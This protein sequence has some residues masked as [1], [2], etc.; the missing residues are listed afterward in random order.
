MSSSLVGLTAILNLRVS[1]SFVAVIL[2]GFCHVLVRSIW[3]AGAWLVWSLVSHIGPPA[4]FCY[5]LTLVLASFVSRAFCGHL[6]S[7]EFFSLSQ[8]YS[9]GSLLL[10]WALPVPLR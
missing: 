1:C 4:V 3:C 7:G 5:I 6:W 8:L 2:C 10:S 9:N